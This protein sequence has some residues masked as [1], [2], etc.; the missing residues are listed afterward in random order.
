MGQTRRKAGFFSC[1]DVFGGL[2][3]DAQHRL[4]TS[5]PALRLRLG[6]IASWKYDSVL[7]RSEVARHPISIG[8]KPTRLGQ[9]GRRF[10]DEPHGVNPEGGC[11]K[12]PDT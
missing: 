5:R 4:K 8:Y 10:D 7:T 3:R 2:D 1:A 12:C 9:L 11:R 6:Q